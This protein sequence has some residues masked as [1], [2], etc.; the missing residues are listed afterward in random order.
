MGEVFESFEQAMG[1]GGIRG[2][3]VFTYLANTIRAGDREGH[4]DVPGLGDRGVGQEPLDVALGDGLWPGRLRQRRWLV[5]SE[6]S[7]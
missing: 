5:A 2:Q 7:G 6:F 3:P 1:A 4:Q